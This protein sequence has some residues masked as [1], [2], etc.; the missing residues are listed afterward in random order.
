MEIF[1]PIFMRALPCNPWGACSN[2]HD[3][4]CFIVWTESCWEHPW[5]PICYSHCSLSPILEFRRKVLLGL[6][7][8]LTRK[9]RKNH[10]EEAHSGANRWMKTEQ[11]WG[12]QKLCTFNVHFQDRKHVIFYILLRGKFFSTFLPNG[13]S[14]LPNGVGWERYFLT[15]FDDLEGHLM[16]FVLFWKIKSILC[17]YLLDRHGALSLK[18]L[19]FMIDKINF[20]SW[21]WRNLLKIWYQKFSIYSSKNDAIQSCHWIA[22]DRTHPHT[23]SF[24]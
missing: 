14:N 18:M 8:F 2:I 1:S 21:E 10:H 24:V 16:F 22:W 15:F 6:A 7:E 11:Q 19:L 13:G 3:F 23:A 5:I 9:T 12:V 4:G 17:G 20:C